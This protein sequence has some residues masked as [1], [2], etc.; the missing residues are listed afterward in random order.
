MR[1]EYIDHDTSRSVRPLILL[2]A[3]WGMS[4]APF[5]G[6]TRSGYDIAVVWDY[7]DLSAPWLDL[8]TPHLS[9]IHI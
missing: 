3:G 7:R 5:A 1:F 6:L 8:L 4:P 2:F 9:L